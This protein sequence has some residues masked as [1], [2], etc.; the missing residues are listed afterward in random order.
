MSNLNDPN[1]EPD[2]PDL[3]RAVQAA[4]SQIGRQLDEAFAPIREQPD[5]IGKVNDRGDL[6]AA[7]TKM[8]VMLASNMQI[9]I[10]QASSISDGMEV[11]EAFVDKMTVLLGCMYLLGRIDESGA[12]VPAAFRDFIDHLP[13]EA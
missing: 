12:A 9:G 3:W 8:A 11:G 1:S 10:S 6:I 4:L 5:L 7:A 2:T 13:G